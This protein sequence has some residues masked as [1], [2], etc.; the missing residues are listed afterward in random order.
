MTWR[1]A[2]DISRVNSPRRA[3]EYRDGAEIRG[4]A[5]SS[6]HVTRRMGPDVKG[7]PTL[8]P[9]SEY[10]SRGIEMSAR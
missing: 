4:I 5:R 7:G 10:S 3:L 2:D 6:N 9:S 1:W 8:I